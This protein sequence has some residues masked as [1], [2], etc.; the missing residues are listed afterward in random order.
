MIQKLLSFQFL[1]KKM[2]KQISIKY[3]EESQF[4]REPEQATEGSAGYDL[5][6]ADT[7]TILPQTAQTIPLDLRFAIPVGFFFDE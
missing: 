4:A 6:A 7:I 3:F 1:F 2:A 5:D